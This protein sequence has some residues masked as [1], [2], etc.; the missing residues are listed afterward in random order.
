MF[1]RHDPPLLRQRRLFVAND[2][3]HPFSIFDWIDYFILFFSIDSKQKVIF[4]VFFEG[5]KNV[6][7]FTLS[8]SPS[9]TAAE[10]S[11]IF[12]RK[13]YFIFYIFIFFFIFLYF[14]YFFFFFFIFQTAL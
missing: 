6:N 5:F 9:K 4:K 13:V 12:S 3:V 10:M 14:F 11:L 2:S 8:I 7:T 1:K